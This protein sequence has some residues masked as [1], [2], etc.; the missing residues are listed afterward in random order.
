MFV[1]E[2]ICF[3]ERVKELCGRLRA[4]KVVLPLNFHENSFNLFNNLNE[5]FIVVLCPFTELQL[6]GLVQKM[7]FLLLEEKHIPC[8]WGRN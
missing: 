1:F 2:H 3:V 6:Q 4:S 5:E 7:N 8:F